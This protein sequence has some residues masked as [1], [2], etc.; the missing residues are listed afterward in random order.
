MI[1]CKKKFITSKA[2]KDELVK[3]KA[4]LQVE[5]TKAILELGHAAKDHVLVLGQT[6]ATTRKWE[7]EKQM[8]T[9]EIE[10]LDGAWEQL[11]RYFIFSNNT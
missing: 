6:Q 11:R 9:K 8:A 2:A 10:E 4:F 3:R 1:E 5:L 7:V